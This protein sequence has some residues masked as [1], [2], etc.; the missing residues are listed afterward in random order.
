MPTARL[1][2]PLLVRAAEVAPCAVSMPVAGTL[3]VGAAKL[4]AETLSSAMLGEEGGC[5]AQSA[6]LKSGSH[7]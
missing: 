5:S 3:T 7:F 4:S 6:G 1:Q 2:V